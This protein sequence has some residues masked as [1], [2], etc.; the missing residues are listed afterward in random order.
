MS[1][2]IYN[3]DNAKY[4]QVIQRVIRLQ[5]VYI[6]GES[7]LIYSVVGGVCEPEVNCLL[8]ELYK[9]AAYEVASDVLASRQVC[10]AIRSEHCRGDLYEDY[11]SE[12]IFT[13][14]PRIIK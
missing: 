10:E 3:D 7:V 9:K 8:C 13:K 2:L 11:E 12:E 1:R 14:C 5:K 4:A 6:G